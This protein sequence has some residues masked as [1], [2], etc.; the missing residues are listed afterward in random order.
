MARS[1]G[2]GWKFL[3]GTSLTFRSLIPPELVV[4]LGVKV[5]LGTPLLLLRLPEAFQL[6]VLLNTRE[7]EEPLGPHELEGR[8]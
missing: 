7:F 6:L 2:E 1:V 4:L 8:V 5:L 3:L